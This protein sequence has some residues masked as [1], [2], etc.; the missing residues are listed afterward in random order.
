MATS[1]HLH[2]AAKE[3][4]GEEEVEVI[5]AA[6][7][8]HT[9]LHARDSRDFAEGIVI[10]S[11][12]FFNARISFRN[13]PGDCFEVSSA[14]GARRSVYMYVY[15]QAEDALLSVSRLVAV[16]QFLPAPRERERERKRSV[17]ARRESLKCFPII[18]KNY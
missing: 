3:E 13:T 8:R 9:S 2:N 14:N 18:A 16:V 6:N 10:L 5:L 12:F 1:A 17:T 15:V 11:V 7:K 4:E